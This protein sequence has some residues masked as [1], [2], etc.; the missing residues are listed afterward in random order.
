MINKHKHL[1][2]RMAAFALM[3]MTW[4]S[5]AFSGYKF[6]PAFPGISH[7]SRYKYLSGIL[8]FYSTLFSDSTILIFFSLKCITIFTNM[9]NPNVM[10]PL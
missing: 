4:V 8:I 1:T 10:I 7:I 2:I 3:A 5:C 9:E 6:K